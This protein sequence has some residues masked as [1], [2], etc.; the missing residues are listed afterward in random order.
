MQQLVSLKYLQHKAKYEP[1]ISSKSSIKMLK[2]FRDV[3]LD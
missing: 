2:I 3:Y 1:I